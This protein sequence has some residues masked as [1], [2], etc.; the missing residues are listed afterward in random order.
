[1]WVESVSSELTPPTRAGTLREARDCS[2][3]LR[4]PQGG[5]RDRSGRLRDVQGPGTFRDVGDQGRFIKIIGE[6]V[7][8]SNTREEESPTKTTSSA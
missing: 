3:R 6:N 1:M 7:Q 8:N 5:F 4:D 2:G